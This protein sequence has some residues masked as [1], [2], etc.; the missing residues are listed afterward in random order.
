DTS[1]L[2]NPTIT[3]STAGTYSVSLTA[4]NGNG[5]NTATQTGYII[6][7]PLP[8]TPTITQFDSLLTATP[9]YPY[10]LWFKTGVLISGAN[11]NKIVISAKGLY[12]VTVSDSNGCT[13][14]AIVNI[15]VVSG[16]NELTINDY[17]NAYPNPTTGNLQLVFNI[18]T[19]GDYTMNISNVLGQ[20]VY[21]DKLHLTGQVTRN[22]DLSGY[23][24]G[25]YFLTVEG[26]NSRAV[27]KILL[28]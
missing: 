5:N 9:G 8:A 1:S 2:Q 4:A 24:K 6:V 16:L 21:S 28:Y 25:V 17:I 3:Y 26:N 14:T 22:I 19:D 18:P 7:N 15:T 13:N 10:Y 12:R 20:S 11:T 27:K 23:S